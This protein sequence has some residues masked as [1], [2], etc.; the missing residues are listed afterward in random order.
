MQPP[1]PPHAPQVWFEVSANTSRV[2]LHAAADGAQHL[3]IS[4]PMEDLLGPLGTLGTLGASAVGGNGGMGGSGGGVGAPSP[5]LEQVLAVVGRGGGAGQG[6]VVPG[7]RGCVGWLVVG[8]A[9]VRR[10]VSAEWACREW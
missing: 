1:P 5:R 4:L 3:G 10:V 7:K 6:C 9:G 8:S 2:H